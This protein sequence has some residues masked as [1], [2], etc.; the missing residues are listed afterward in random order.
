[1]PAVSKLFSAPHAQRVSPSAAYQRASFEHDKKHGKYVSDRR[2]S[3]DALAGENP[4]IFLVYWLQ[5]F[6]KRIEI[7]RSRLDEEESAKTT[8][9]F[10]DPPKQPDS[11][12]CT[13][14]LILPK[15]AKS[16]RASTTLHDSVYLNPTIQPALANKSNTINPSLLS[17]LP[18]CL[19]LTGRKNSC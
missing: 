12:T 2:T 10:S 19:S 17:S 14:V 1:M 13:I 15:G 18:L 9:A 4:A 11:S 5:L 8:H 16:M 7:E 6:S 3:E